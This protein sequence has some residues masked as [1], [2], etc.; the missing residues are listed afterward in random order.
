MKRVL[1]ITTNINTQPGYP[2]GCGI[3]SAI[4]KKNGYKVD[5]IYF[6]EIDGFSKK[7]DYRLIDKKVLANDVVCFSSFTIQYKFVEQIARYLKEKYPDKRRILGGYHATTNYEELK[8]TGL[9]HEIFRGEAEDA[10]IDLVEGKHFDS[11]QM[12]KNINKYYEIDYDLFPG[13]TEKIMKKHNGWINIIFARGCPF[14]C[15]YCWNGAIRSSYKVTNKEYL[16]QVTPENAIK[17]VQ[18]I[19][20]KYKDFKV[21]NIQ[22]DLFTWNKPWIREFCKLLKENLPDL[23]YTCNLRP[24]MF[25]LETLNILKESG[26]IRVI[27]GI[28]SHSKRIRD[29]V[30]NRFMSNDEIMKAVKM[31]NGVGFRKGCWA[32]YIIGCPTETLQE[33]LDTIKFAGE[34]GTAGVKMCL[35]LP[36]KG[37]PIYKYCIDNDLLDVGVYERLDNYRDETCIKFPEYHR[38]FIIWCQENFDKLLNYFK[39]CDGYYEKKYGKEIAVL[40]NGKYDWKD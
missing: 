4:L 37:T 38:D 1:F 39:K 5:G 40:C 6:D 2:V 16:R 29:E 20:E 34:L 14:N 17:M 31:C 22:D 15:S 27:L 19:V 28:E 10:I 11:P 36:F 3:L 26:C 32:L 21:L 8:G 24:K 23:E 33:T 18:R 9:Y 30:L 12:T 35:M 7:L 13:V 25:D